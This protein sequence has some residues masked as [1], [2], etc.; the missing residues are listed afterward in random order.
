MG[1]D[2]KIENKADE[3]KGKAKQ[4]VGEAT[5]DEQLQA[6]GKTDE[7]KGHLKQAGEKIKDAFKG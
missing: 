1:T 6:E 4:G 7:T 2:D 5:G 3:L